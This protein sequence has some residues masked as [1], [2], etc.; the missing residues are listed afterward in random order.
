[1]QRWLVRCAVGV[2]ALVL[3]AVGA[4]EFPALAVLV[5][6]ICGVSALGYLAIRARGPMPHLRPEHERDGRDVERYVPP[7]STS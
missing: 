7:T 2:L 5:A 1:M 4:R 3:F 6:I